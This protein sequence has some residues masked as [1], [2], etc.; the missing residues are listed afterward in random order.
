MSRG[1]GRIEIAIDRLLQARPD[2]SFTVREIVRHIYGVDAYGDSKP[3]G[4]QSRAIRRALKH[5]MARHSTWEW[6]IRTTRR[7]RHF[8]PGGEERMLYNTANSTSKQRVQ[9]GHLFDEH[10]QVARER[11]AAALRQ[12]AAALNQISLDRRAG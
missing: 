8:G 3:T 2:E 12:I 9:L 5:I 10:G 1:P 6:S 7:N 11:N 4:S